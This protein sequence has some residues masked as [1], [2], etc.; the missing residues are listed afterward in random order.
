MTKF[1]FNLQRVLDIRMT[2]ERLRQNQLALERKKEMEIHQKI[3]KLRKE[4][5][6]EYRRGQTL[7]TS[8]LADI[9]AFVAHQRYME[10][11]ERTIERSGVDLERQRAVVETARQALVEA[12]RKRKLL[13]KLKEKRLT[14]FKKEEEA[15]EQKIIDEIGGTPSARWT[16]QDTGTEACR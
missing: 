14:T 15:A 7:L 16:S 10:A 13:E 1:K 4:Q 12:A 8:S 5:S 3:D 2:E 11:L 6:E 9:R